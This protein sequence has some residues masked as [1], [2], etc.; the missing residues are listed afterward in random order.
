MIDANLAWMNVML[1]KVNMMLTPRTLMFPG[2]QILK[3]Y[4]MLVC[5]FGKST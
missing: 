3:E 2:Y 1:G 4:N 5:I